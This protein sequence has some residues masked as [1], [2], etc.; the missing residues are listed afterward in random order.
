MAQDTNKIEKT[1]EIAYKVLVEPWVT[2]KTT[3]LAE[4]NKYVFKV[5]PKTSKIQI[6]DSIESLYKVEVVSVNVINIAKKKR[7][8]GRT[9][10]WKSGFR[11]AVITLKKGDVIEFFEGK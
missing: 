1:S 2:E 5:S 10:G 11:K 6:K 4:L 7:T 8:R 9:T 3:Q